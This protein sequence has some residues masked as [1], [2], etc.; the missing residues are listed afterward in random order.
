MPPQAQTTS[1]QCTPPWPPLGRWGFV[2]ETKKCLQTKKNGIKAPPFT[3]IVRCSEY[4]QDFLEMFKNVQHITVDNIMNASRIRRTGELHIDTA[5]QLGAR[6][7][8]EAIK[9]NKETNSNKKNGINKLS[10][11]IGDPPAKPLVC[12]KRCRDSEDGGKTGEITCNPKV[13]DAI[14]K[15]V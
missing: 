10:K 6:I 11:H 3:P 12:V 8:T 15:R 2:S 7:R 5:K 4:C 9:I 13:V 1:D 14:V